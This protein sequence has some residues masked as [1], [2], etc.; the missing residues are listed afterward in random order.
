MNNASKGLGVV[1]RG[2]AQYLTFPPRAQQA[3]ERNHGNLVQQ[4][5]L[6]PKS[7]NR[8]KAK[9]SQYLEQWVHE[10]EVLTRKAPA[11]DAVPSS[12]SL[13]R[14]VPAKVG[15]RADGA[16]PLFETWAPMSSKQDAS[17]T[18]GWL[19]GPLNNSTDS[20]SDH[21]Q[22]AQSDV[23]VR[24]MPVSHRNTK[25]KNG[26]RIVN[27][28]LRHRCLTAETPDDD[29]LS[30]RSS[31]LYHLQELQ[32]TTLR[33][34][35][36]GGGPGATSRHKQRKHVRKILTENGGKFRSHVNMMEATADSWD[37]SVGSTVSSTRQLSDI[38]G[39]IGEG[40]KTAG[41]SEVVTVVEG[42][43]TVTEIAATADDAHR[44]KRS[45]V[46]IVNPY[47]S[48]EI[49]FQDQLPGKVIG[50]TGAWDLFVQQLRERVHAQTMAMISALASLV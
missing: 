2:S 32:A 13:F 44:K 48:Q 12:N 3:I 31:D 6:H 20:S 47:T 42:T 45:G 38:A 7:P 16:M 37:P 19:F 46:V 27:S 4:A 1:G 21:S 28:S 36:G 5:S 11:S 15:E 24:T 17:A 25:S 10:Q 18:P 23:T 29:C 43:A 34:M 39:A 33:A 50:G 22:S 26:N 9:Q 40:V 8:R 30:V 35:Q 41:S 14:T 49:H